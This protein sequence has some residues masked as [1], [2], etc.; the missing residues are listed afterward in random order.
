MG[1]SVRPAASHLRTARMR[2]LKRVGGL[3]LCH[4]ITILTADRHPHI[5]LAH[6]LTV[7][8]SA[9]KHE[10]PG[11]HQSFSYCHQSSPYCAPGLLIQP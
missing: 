2:S 11:H 5:T 10:S 7:D 1:T 4:T 6:S 3:I 8:S 9:A